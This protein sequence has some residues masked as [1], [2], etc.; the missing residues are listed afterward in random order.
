MTRC[1]LTPQPDPPDASLTGLCPLH[2]CRD[3]RGL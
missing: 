2:R 3:A 1:G